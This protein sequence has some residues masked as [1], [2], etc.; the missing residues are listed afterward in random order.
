VFASTGLIA[1]IDSPAEFQAVLAHEIGHARLGHIVQIGARIRAEKSRALV[2]Q[3]LGA[4]L[5]AVN[6]QA[7][8]GVMAGSSSMAAQSMLAFT[9]DEERSADDYAVKLLK[10]AKIDPS[11]LL[12]IFQKMQNLH[13]DQKVNPNNINHP[14]TEERIKNIKIAI[15]DSGSAIH[16]S[17]NPNRKLSMIQAKLAGYLDTAERVKIIYPDSD[18]SDPAL[19]AR[20]ISRMRS[21]DLAGAKTGATTLISRHP[22]SPY[23]YELMGDIEYQSGNYDASAAAYDKSIQRQK[24]D[25]KRQVELALALVL[26]ERNKAGDRMRATELAK[27]VIL[28]EPM[29]LAWRVLAKSDPE[30]IEY[31]LTEYYYMIHDTAQAKAHAKAAIKKL[32]P[33]SPEALKAADILNAK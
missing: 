5:L 28:S 13:E 12:S 30:R 33:D 26:S 11:A 17:M 14:L 27:R 8:V 32:P 18:K 21:G 4:G 23:F 15:L 3:A 1:K 7:A 24:A 6:P 20:T 19:Y 10:K 31:Y 9:R 25:G 22:D 16:D 2:M 29:P